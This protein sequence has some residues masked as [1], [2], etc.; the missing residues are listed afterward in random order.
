MTIKLLTTIFIT[1]ILLSCNFFQ[2]N[3]P[4]DGLYIKKRS[5]GSL[6]HVE[7][8]EKGD[9]TGGSVSFDSNGRVYTFGG[10]DKNSQLHGP[11]LIYYPDGTINDFDSYLNGVKEGLSIHYG[12]SGFPTRQSYFRNGKKDGEEYYFDEQ[13]DTLR[14]EVYDKGKLIDTIYK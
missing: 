11:L 7:F 4:N 3:K 5:D 1:S 6:E 10:Y 12:E 14:I 8:Y 2:N 9:L 13:G